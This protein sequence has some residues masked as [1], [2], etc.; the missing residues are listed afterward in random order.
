MSAVKAHFPL[1]LQCIGLYGAG[2]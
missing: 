1:T 2:I